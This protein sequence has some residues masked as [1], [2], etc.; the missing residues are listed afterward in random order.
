MGD[1]ASALSLTEF[2]G[3]SLESDKLLMKLMFDCLT[4]FVIKI[5]DTLGLN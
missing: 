4:D 1:A 5:E 2:L 3:F